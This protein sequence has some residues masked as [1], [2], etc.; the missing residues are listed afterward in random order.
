[1]F[2]GCSTNGFYPQLGV[3]AALTEIGA[4]GFTHAEVMLY[5][6][7]QYA[8]EAFRT[9]GSAARSAGVEVTAIHLEPDMHMPFDPE[10]AVVADAWRNF[11]IAIEG[12]LEL[13][14]RTIIWQGPIAVEYPVESG[15]EPLL[16]AVY[17]LDR[18][19]REAGVRL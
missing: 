1:M 19:C 8:L 12:A 7:R 15:M 2:I 10:P 14:A 9:Y 16:E 4:L 18:R 13:G 17:E 6:Q 11:D 3:T 5:H